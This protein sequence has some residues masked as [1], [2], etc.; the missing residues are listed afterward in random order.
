VVVVRP[1]SKQWTV[2]SKQWTVISKQW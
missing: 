1:I 2:I